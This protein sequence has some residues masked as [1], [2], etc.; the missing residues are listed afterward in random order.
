MIIVFEGPDGGGK[1]FVRAA[2]ER[3]TE[4]ANTVVTRFF[5][6]QMVYARYFN[7]PLWASVPAWKS[8]ME[9]VSKFVRDF[10]PLVVYCTADPK[11]LAKR[12]RRRGETV[13][14]QPNPDEIDV[15]FEE[16]FIVTGVN[17]LRLDTTRNPPMN[18]LIRKIERAVKATERTCP[19]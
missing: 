2:F 19:T 13:L 12:I 6:S 18:S 15:L 7:R 1:D 14:K 17:V 4:Y 3:E 16:M 11:V 5:F 9:T 8:Y 10:H